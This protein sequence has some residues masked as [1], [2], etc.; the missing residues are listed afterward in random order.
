MAK[1]RSDLIWAGAL[2][3]IILIV[4]GTWQLDILPDLFTTSSGLV[5]VDKQIQYHMV[6]KYGGGPIASKSNTYQLYDSD[7]QTILEDNLDTDAGGLDQ[8]GAPW[9]SG[10]TMYLRYESS[11]DKQW[12]QFVVPQMN[13]Q[14]AEAATYN[15]IRMESFTIGTYTSS[16]CKLSNGTAITDGAWTHDVSNGDGTTPHFIYSALNTGSDNTGLM[17][18]YDPLYG[19][20]WDVEFYITFSGTGYEKIIVYDMDYDFTLGTTHY[21][22][23]TLDPYALTKHKVGSVYKSLGTQDV[24]W[25][26]DLTGLSGSDSVT[27][28]IELKAYADHVY[29]QNHGGSFGTEA[30]E[31]DEITVTLDY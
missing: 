17:S 1:G 15:T 7:G 3:V 14:D 20:N 30:Y 2:I 23:K 10:K 18:S 26:L 4:S 6:D 24:S 16:T 8:T 5:N 19:Q 29:A 31:L 28:Q 9:P 22:G 13:E 11:N 12:W 27:M 25:W 21:V